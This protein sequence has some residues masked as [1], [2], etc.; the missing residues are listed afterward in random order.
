MTLTTYQR[1]VGGKTGF[2][3]HNLLNQ[4]RTYFS[5]QHRGGLR[6]FFETKVDVILKRNRLCLALRKDLPATTHQPL[7]RDK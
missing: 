7:S 3:I 4:V 2:L 1:Q 6:Y 5:P